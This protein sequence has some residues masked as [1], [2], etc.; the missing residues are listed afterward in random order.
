M[1]YIIIGDLQMIIKT[2]VKLMVLTILLIISIAVCYMGTALAEPNH[3]S[4]GRPDIEQIKAK[5][6]PLLAEFKAGQMKN[7]APAAPNRDLLGDQRSFFVYNFKNV[8]YD[9]I[10]ATLRKVGGHCYIYVDNTLWTGNLITQPQIETIASTFDNTYYPTETAYFGQENSPGIDND[11]RVTVLITRIVTSSN[12]IIGYFD[13]TDELP[14]S[15]A[16]TIGLRSNQREMFYMNGYDYIPANPTF[17]H[18]LSHEFFHMIQYNQNPKEE[19]WVGEGMADNAAYIVGNRAL[20]DKMNAFM[21]NPSI[22]LLPLSYDVEPIAHYGASFLFI[23]YLFEQYG[24]SNVTEQQN[25]MRNLTRSGD[26]GTRTID[27]ALASA[28]YPDVKFKDIFADWTLTNYINP[29]G[30]SKY[31]YK[32]FVINIDPLQTH[33]G[34]PVRDRSFDLNYWS[35]NYIM[36][37][38]AAS[39]SHVLEFSGSASGTYYPRVCMFNKDGTIVVKN[40][41]LNGDN[42]GFIDLAEFGITYNSVLLVPSLTAE[43]GP[44]KYH[45]AVGYAGPTVGIYP[46][47]I[48]A[49]DMYIT[50]KSVSK[51]QVIVKRSGGPDEKVTMNTAQK[52]LYTGTYH[53]LY[54]GLFEVSVTGED[55]N[56]LTG[57]IKTEFEIRKLQNRV[58]NMISFGDGRGYFS[59]RIDMTDS[60]TS[61]TGESTTDYPKVTVVPADIEEK[62]DEASTAK[63]LKCLTGVRTFDNIP[64]RVYKSSEVSFNFRDITPSNISAGQLGIYE[65]DASSPSGFRYCESYMKDGS[66]IAANVNTTG[67]YYLMFD[68]VAPAVSEMRRANGIIDIQITDGGSGVA[69]DKVKVEAPEGVEYKYFETE[70]LV[71]ISNYGGSGAIKLTVADRSQNA[72]AYN[73]NYQ[74][75]N[76]SN[77]VSSLY[78]APN[79]AVTF[80]NITWQGGA[81]PF[82]IK[83]HDVY[84]NTVASYD[85]VFARNY[86]WTLANDSMDIV[87]NGIYYFSVEDNNGVTAKYGKIAVLK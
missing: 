64:K 54:S 52:N 57:T 79:P 61:A 85:G 83:I 6:T 20:D 66:M 10:T 34:Y 36:F 7:M 60:Q 71:R 25:F 30:F 62:S 9:K 2:G 63:E 15:Q 33:T 39:K 41:T 31:K 68:D 44:T 73:I 53:V 3:G 75:G 45:Y 12:S 32:D 40:I 80:A 59:A 55:E 29:K 78:S 35:A 84:S 47:P 18:T 76:V 4:A 38:Y 67:D 81:P 51:P 65:K 77:D 69:A 17:M 50:V 16:Q 24:G 14:D 1:A 43:R 5:V 58:L 11:I 70:G 82:K 21:K 48:L 37:K 74:A 22:S 46:N 26:K 19:S 49:D 8:G 13:P 86:R 56:N 28:G 72:A 87:S 23:R 42:Q 27:F